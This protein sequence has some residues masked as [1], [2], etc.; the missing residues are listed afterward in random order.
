MAI[1]SLEHNLYKFLFRIDEG[2]LEIYKGGL[3]VTT[4]NELPKGVAWDNI[5]NLSNRQDH[6]I[7]NS[8]LA[9]KILEFYLSKS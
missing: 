7:E 2:L 4:L 8:E 3:L 5:K 9:R 6:I 1:Y